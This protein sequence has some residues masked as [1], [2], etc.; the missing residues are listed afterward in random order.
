MQDADVGAALA[1]GNLS[2]CIS[3]HQHSPQDV[4]SL[5]FNCPSPYTFAAEL[6]N[7]A[8]SRQVGDA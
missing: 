1:S 7:S 4:V 6:V 5:V 2:R 3:Q 8:V